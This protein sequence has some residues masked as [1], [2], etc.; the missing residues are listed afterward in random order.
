MKMAKLSRQ[1]YYSIKDKEKKLNCYKVNIPKEVANQTN[2]IDK[3]L[4]IY[5]KDGKIII[6]KK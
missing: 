3:E 6:D 2:L 1:M 4:I 5:A